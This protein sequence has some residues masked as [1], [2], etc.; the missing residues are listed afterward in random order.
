MRRCWP[1][2]RAEAVAH[3]SD[4]RRYDG[5]VR[6]RVVS[7]RFGIA[8]QGGPTDGDDRQACASDRGE[9]KDALGGRTRRGAG[10][11]AA[12]HGELAELA[13]SAAEDAERLLVNA[14]RALRRA[15]ATAE[16]RASAGS[17]TRLRGGGVDGSLARSTTW[18]NWSRSAPVPRDRAQ[19]PR[20]E[21][22]AFFTHQGCPNPHHFF[23]SK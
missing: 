11:R 2:G 9:A 15:K 22:R 8:G 5:G 7:D 19:S 10:N 14:K 13:A 1:G 4:T 3:Q 6:E 23:R 20:P 17:T 21:S 16:R 12:G 18:P